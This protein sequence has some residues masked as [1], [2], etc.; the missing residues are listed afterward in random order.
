MSHCYAVS[1]RDITSHGG[2]LKSIALENTTPTPN[3]TGGGFA[4]Q[5]QWLQFAGRPEEWIESGQLAG[6]YAPY[7]DPNNVHPFFAWK[8]SRDGFQVWESPARSGLNRY[9]NYTLGTLNKTAAGNSGGIA[10]TSERFA[11]GPRT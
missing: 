11:A 7:R 8:T 2:V 3:V 5:E 6:C 10:L 4:T 1:Y 9:T